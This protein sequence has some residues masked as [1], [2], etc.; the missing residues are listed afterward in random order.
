MK[1]TGVCHWNAPNTGATNSSGFTALPGGC[2]GDFGLFIYLGT[3]GDWWSSTQDGLGFNYI[4][5]ISYLNA[6]SNSGLYVPYYGFSV[7]LI[8]DDVS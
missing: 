8:K 3:N 7:R 1:E 5:Y 4:R 6:N 2:R